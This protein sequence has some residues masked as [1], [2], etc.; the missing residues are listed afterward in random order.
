MMPGEYVTIED[1]KAM[2]VGIF[3][4]EPMGLHYNREQKRRYLKKHRHDKDAS[5]CIYCN[6]KTATITDD[7]CDSICELCGIIKKRED[8]ND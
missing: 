1:L 4:G 5:Y 6:G 8:K 3:N 2:G 7:Y